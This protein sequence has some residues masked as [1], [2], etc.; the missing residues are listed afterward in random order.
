MRFPNTAVQSFGDTKPEN[1]SQLNTGCYSRGFL[2]SSQPPAW[3]TQINT[4]SGSKPSFWRQCDR[5]AR[6]TVKSLRD[7]LERI[8]TVGRRDQ[9]AAMV[10]ELVD[11]LLIC[12]AE[13]QQLHAQRGWNVETELSFAEQ[14]W[15]SP[16][17][18]ELDEKFKQ[19]RAK[20]DWRAISLASL[21]PS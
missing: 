7:Y 14:L 15:L 2:F 8:G 13:V 11:I 18:T 10:D 16:Y 3:N 1:I 19:Q 5:R 21:Q 17:R 20:N 12:A 4:P 9:R 6:R